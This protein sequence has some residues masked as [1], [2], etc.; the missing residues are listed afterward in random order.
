VWHK[1]A[2]I[3]EGC[4]GGPLSARGQREEESFLVLGRE[5]HWLPFTEQHCYWA[6][7]FQVF[8]AESHSS[9][10]NR[11]CGTPPPTFLWYWGLNSKP[12]P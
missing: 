1:A 5:S 2:G 3:S 11:A 9:L 7:V 10:V 4:D 6:R 12:T 8:S